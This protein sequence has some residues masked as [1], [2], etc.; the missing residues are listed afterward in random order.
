MEG[1]FSVLPPQN[2]GMFYFLNDENFAFKELMLACA[3]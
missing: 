1:N 2:V 3:S